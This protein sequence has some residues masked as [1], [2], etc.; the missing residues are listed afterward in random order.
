MRENITNAVCPVCGRKLGDH[1]PDMESLLAEL[2]YDGKDIR[3]V[4]PEVVVEADF[5]HALDEEG[6]SLDEPH[7]L[8][9]V[10][11]IR[12]DSSGKGTS[13]EVLQ[14]IKGVNNG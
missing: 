2:S 3:I 12:F 4:T 1:V 14:I 13:Y 10:I 9:A 7:P 6:F 11:K 5:D 8:V